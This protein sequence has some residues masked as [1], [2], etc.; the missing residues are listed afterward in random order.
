MVAVFYLDQLDPEVLPSQTEVWQTTNVFDVDYQEA[1]ELCETLGRSL[2]DKKEFMDAL[3]KAETWFLETCT[4]CKCFSDA[5]PV[6]AQGLFDLIVS[7]V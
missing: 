3:Q 7:D 4:D 6:V 5:S 2:R 1:T